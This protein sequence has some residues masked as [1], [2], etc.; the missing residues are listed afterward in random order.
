MPK[1]ARISALLPSNLVNKMK[2]IASQEG[3]T[4]S[5]ILKDALELW[6]KRRLERDSKTLAGLSFTDLPTEEEWDIIQTENL[7]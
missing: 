4:Q 5:F 2:E 1:S 3:F 6:F 7:T